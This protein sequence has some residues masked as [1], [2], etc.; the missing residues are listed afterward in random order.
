[1]VAF[2]EFVSRLVAAPNP[3]KT[4]F[5]PAGTRECS[6]TERVSIENSAPAA[7]GLAALHEIARER[8]ALA[9]FEATLDV[10]DAMTFDAILN[11]PFRSLMW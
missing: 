3:L 8:V 1:M 10:I 2:R 11:A 5:M 9:Y 7:S 6:T 4:T